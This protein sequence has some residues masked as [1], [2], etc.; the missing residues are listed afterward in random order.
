MY[1][2]KRLL[3]GLTMAERDEATLKYA[4]MIARMA[5]SEK[6]YFIH[7]APSLEIPQEIREQYSDQFEP[8]DE[9]TEDRMAEV[10]RRI[11]PQWVI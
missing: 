1:R 10:V 4:A 5:E 8:V 9:V 7:V 2:Y 11:A 6:V 3:V